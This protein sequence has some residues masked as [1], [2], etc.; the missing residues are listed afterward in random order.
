V[1]LPGC[2]AAADASSRT[3]AAFLYPQG[4]VCPGD[5]EARDEGQDQ[6]PRS[7]CSLDGVADDEAEA[8]F[9][10]PRPVDEEASR[11]DEEAPQWPC[12]PREEQEQV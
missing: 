2:P 1:L 6:E 5:E 9:A 10:S 3:A 7:H 12:F 4:A 11:G 8:C